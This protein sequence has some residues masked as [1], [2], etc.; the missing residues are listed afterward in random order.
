M[1]TILSNQRTNDNISFTLGRRQA[2][3][4]DSRF[5]KR[6]RD[7]LHKTAS[8]IASLHPLEA[9]RLPFDGVISSLTDIVKSVIDVHK[10]DYLVGKAAVTELDARFHTL[11]QSMVSSV[12][13]VLG[14]EEFQQVLIISFYYKEIF[15]II[16]FSAMKIPCQKSWS[17]PRDSKQFE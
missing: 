2:Y 11:L 16:N 3:R 8:I 7:L 12:S 15:L 9:D 17:I 6:T 1:Q 4:N 13:I 14:R 5:V 10:P